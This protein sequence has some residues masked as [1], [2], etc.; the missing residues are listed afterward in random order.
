MSRVPGGEEV[1]TYIEERTYYPTGYDP[2]N[3]K[4]KYNVIAYTLGVYYRGDGRWMVSPQREGH[5]QMT[6]TGRLLWLPRKFQQMRW[7]RFDFETACA[8]A[9]QNVDKLDTLRGRTW[10][11]LMAEWEATA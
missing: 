8:L 7:C 6:H 1:T 5:S 4:H 9:E 2:D 3:P 11:D 10:A